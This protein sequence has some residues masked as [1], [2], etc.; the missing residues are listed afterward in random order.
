MIVEPHFPDSFI[1]L[2][3]MIVT[4]ELDVDRLKARIDGRATQSL[5]ASIDTLECGDIF[6]EDFYAYLKRKGMPLAKN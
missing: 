5:F 2:I 4:S 3:S 1:Q 6:V